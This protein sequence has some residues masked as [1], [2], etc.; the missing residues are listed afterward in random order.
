MKNVLDSTKIVSGEIEIV[1]GV[2]V[3][4]LLIELTNDS[5][6]NVQMFVNRIN[7]Y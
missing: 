2:L 6:C 1:Q 4:W 3:E 7:K 5:R